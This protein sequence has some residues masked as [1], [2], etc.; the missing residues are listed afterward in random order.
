VLMIRRL[1]RSLSQPSIRTQAVI[2]AVAPV[3][4]AD[5]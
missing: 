4:R 2:A 5:P 1:P 3:A